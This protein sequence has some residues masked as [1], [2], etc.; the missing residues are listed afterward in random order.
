MIMAI[1][2]ACINAESFENPIIQVNG[3]GSSK[4]FSALMMD[5][6]VEYATLQNSQCFPLY[7]YERVDI[8]S[9]WKDGAGVQSAMSVSDGALTSYITESETIKGSGVSGECTYYKRK[10]AIRDEAL[11]KFQEVYKDSTISKEAMFYYIYALLNHPVYKTKFADNL[12]KMLP[13]IPF[14]QDFWGFERAGR[15]LSKIHLDYEG[16]APDYLTLD[17]Q[18]EIFQP[19]QD[20]SEASLDSPFVVLR[21]DIDSM[22]EALSR[23]RSKG[24]F[25][26]DDRERFSTL[27]A[28][29]RQA[30]VSLPDSAFQITKIR[31]SKG[32]KWGYDFV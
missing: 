22:Y 23:A 6:I 8:E 32:R 18:S 19:S 26:P 21:K 16:F 30:L 5:N 28:Q 3:I 17:S 24:L 4:D 29:A 27:K 7:Y 10:D 11:R 2:I 1:T 15:A 12:S 9:V 14:M 25:A 20:H 13:R 31:M